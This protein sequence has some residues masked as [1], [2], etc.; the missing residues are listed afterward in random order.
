MHK[1]F[2]GSLV[3]LAMLASPLLVSAQST[4]SSNAS[5]IATLTALVAQ[6]TQELQQ[7]LAARAISNSNTTASLD[8]NPS[9]GAAPLT[10]K[11]SVT[12]S[13]A[14]G[15]MTSDS[16]GFG[17][18]TSSFVSEYACTGGVSTPGS[19]LY[20]ATHTYANAGTYTAVLIDP[21]CSTSDPDCGLKGKVIASTVITVGGGTANGT[22]SACTRYTDLIKGDTDST[23][24]GR[25]S[26]L[27]A[28]LGMAN[29]TGYYGAQ[30]SIAYNNKCGNLGNAQP[31]FVAG[32]SQYTDADFGFSFWYPSGWSVQISQ[33]GIA[34]D[35]LIRSLVVSD[36]SG[37]QLF[38]VD[39]FQNV[40]GQS[41]WVDKNNTESY[42]FDS[43]ASVWTHQ[44]ISGG[45]V[46]KQ[47]ADTSV[48]TMGGL[49]MFSWNAFP[50]A[51]D[52]LIP[53]SASTFV[54]VSSIAG[55]T[56]V[57]LAQTIV[58]TNPVVAIPV[59]TAQQIVTIQ[60]ESAAYAGK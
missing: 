27:Q 10:V 35:R 39:D 30:T 47:T 56:V 41:L 21:N 2:V 5:L 24:N 51:S 12:V 3:A 4:S 1:K 55:A 15:D 58:A 32:M 23:T 13:L 42:F 29:V 26:S 19:C 50:S 17:D 8:S 49:H 28:F 43:T 44:T 37:K 38:Y 22:A 14:H 25:V 48:N 52:V 59:S 20:G 11:F 33:T 40:N 54:G 7:L 16:I 53:L 46:S 36:T 60:A 45:S 6:L 31:T 57:P 9:S 34:T 18:G